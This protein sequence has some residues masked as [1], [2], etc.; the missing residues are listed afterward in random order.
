MPLSKKLPCITRFYFYCYFSVQLKM[1]ENGSVSP[2]IYQ[3]ST[4]SNALCV[5]M[6]TVIFLDIVR[7]NLDNLLKNI[8]HTKLEFRL[9]IY[10]TIWMDIS[11]FCWSEDIAF[12]ITF[13]I[14]STPNIFQQ[15]QFQSSSA[16]SKKSDTMWCFTN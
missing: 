10:M 5:T 16:L 4:F 12:I 8:E 6:K 9:Y 13:I 11:V 3:S 7:G 2:S 14:F 1:K 15:G